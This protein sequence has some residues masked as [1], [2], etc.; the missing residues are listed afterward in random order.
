MIDPTLIYSTYLGGSQ[1]DFGNAIAIDSSGAA[2][3]TEGISEDEID[4]VGPRLLLSP[5]R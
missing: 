1:P 5:L 3:V 2:Y 4:Q